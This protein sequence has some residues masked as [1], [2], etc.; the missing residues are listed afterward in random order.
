MVESKKKV[1]EELATDK[2]KRDASY[3]YGSGSPEPM[4]NGAFRGALASGLVSRVAKMKNRKAEAAVIAAGTLSGALAGKKYNDKK[5]DSAKRARKWLADHNSEKKYIA[6][7]KKIYKEASEG[8]PIASKISDYKD[9]YSAVNAIAEENKP[10]KRKA[11]ELV[12]DTAIGSM[13]GAGISAIGGKKFRAIRALKGASIG[14]AGIA[15]SDTIDNATESTGAD[16]SR[17]GSI[18]G[19]GASFAAGGAVEPAA[20]RLLGRYINNEKYVKSLKA[21]KKDDRNWL[22]KKLFKKKQGSDVDFLAGHA[23]KGK[24]LSTAFKGAGKQTLKSAGKAGLFGLGLGVGI[25]YLT[26]KLKKDDNVK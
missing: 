22:M 21:P 12:S 10:K 25:D 11:S 5:V 1:I 3:E 18:A 15:A 9:P 14:G 16:K 7:T 19:L 23:S 17:I 4:A 6:E 26:H 2:A 20:N 13:L 8:N 24:K